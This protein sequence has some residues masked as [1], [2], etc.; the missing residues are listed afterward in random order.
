MRLR[1]GA[2]F[3][4]RDEQLVGEPKQVTS[5]DNLYVFIICIH[6]HMANERL[7]IHEIKTRLLPSDGSIIIA[8]IC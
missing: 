4:F 5:T 6:K 1:G 8:Y 7:I 2:G 3:I